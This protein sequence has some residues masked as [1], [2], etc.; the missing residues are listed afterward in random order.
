M[1][2]AGAVQ[3]T[4]LSRHPQVS[5]IS[6]KC[7]LYPPGVYYIPQVSIISPRCLSHPPGV[8]YIPQ[9]SIISPRYLLYPPGVYYIPQVSVISPRYLLY[10][11][12]GG[13]NRLSCTERTEPTPAPLDRPK[14]ARLVRDSDSDG[15]RL[16]QGRET[17]RTDDSDSDGR[18]LGQRRETTRAATGDD[19]DS[20]GRRLGHRR[21]GQDS[22]AL[23]CAA[24]DGPV[25]RRRRQIILYG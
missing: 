19:S 23:R 24:P 7:L 10:P 14:G 4:A 3:L 2:G 6:P 15:R 8:Y 16:G 18:R 12:S 5:I 13:C 1:W 22:S 17:T 20:D 11:P 25:R 21:L 9:V